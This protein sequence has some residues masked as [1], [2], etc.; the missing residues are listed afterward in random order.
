MTAEEIGKARIQS[1][2]KLA[3]THGID[4]MGW[5]DKRGK[6][7]IS[8]FNASGDNE[9][10]QVLQKEMEKNGWIAHP[11]EEKNEGY[12]MDFGMQKPPTDLK[13]QKQADIHGI[14]PVVF[15]MK[16]RFRYSGVKT[17]YVNSVIYI[18]LMVLFLVPTH[19]SSLNSKHM[20]LI[21]VASTILL[22]IVV[23]LF[24]WIIVTADA[25]NLIIRMPFW[26]DIQS[27]PISDIK[28]ATLYRDND[29]WYANV[30]GAVFLSVKL[31]SGKSFDIY[32]PKR[33]RG[34]LLSFLKGKLPIS[35]S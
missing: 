17:G 2:K 34:E 23:A 29:S 30:K 6:E 35:S 22:S 11:V 12:Y 28:K 8:V 27:F 1:A 13:R 26:F 15:Y 4:V 16:E 21:M 3:E 25:S 9:K 33:A 19:L 18:S 10:L 32:I 20:I 14:E 31:K 5:N 7:F 24:H